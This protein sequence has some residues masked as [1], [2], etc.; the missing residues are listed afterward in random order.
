MPARPIPT[1]RRPRMRAPRKAASTWAP[2]MIVPT[3]RRCRLR[4]AL[5]GQRLNDAALRDVRQQVQR[6]I[7]AGLA[8]AIGAGHDIERAEDHL[9]F[10]QGSIAG[11]RKSGYH[12]HP[13][14]TRYG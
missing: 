4:P 10:A 14:R 12:G 3:S 6:A 7:K 2:A 1:A 5:G 13:N 9:D 8:A 11:D